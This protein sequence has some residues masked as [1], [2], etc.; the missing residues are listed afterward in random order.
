[1]RLIVKRVDS[2]LGY[3]VAVCKARPKD[4]S[5]QRPTLHSVDFTRYL[6]LREKI[7]AQ[8]KSERAQYDVGGL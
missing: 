8:E 5:G 3:K 2:G 7:N 6:L 1:M 4:V